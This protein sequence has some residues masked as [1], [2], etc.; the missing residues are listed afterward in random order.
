MDLFS[1]WHTRMICIVLGRK[2][3]IYYFNF[4]FQFYFGD[5]NLPHDK[6]IKLESANNGGWFPAELLLKF[7]KLS[8]MISRYI[9]GLI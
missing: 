8:N 1:L 7:N 9:V 5:A 4:Y 3:Y 2:V 6:F